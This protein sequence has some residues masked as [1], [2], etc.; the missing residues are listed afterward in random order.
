MPFDVSGAGSKSWLIVLYVGSMS[1]PPARVLARLF[2]VFHNVSYYAK[3]LS[4]FQERG[5]DEFW[6]GYMAFRAAPMGPVEAPVVTATFYN[7][8]PTLVDAAVPAVW[9]IVSPAEAIEL[10]ATAISTALTNAVDWKR[11]D[12]DAV[13]IADLVFDAMGDVPDAGRALFGAYRALPL[14]DLP[15][16]RLWHASTL[17]REY[18]GDGHNIALS[19]QG[20]DG[21]ECHV[22]LAGK[23]VGNRDVIEKIRGWDAPSWD[24]AHERL[25]KRGL[26]DAAGALTDNGA[27][28]RRHIE[29][30]TDRLAA[31]P[32]LALGPAGVDNVVAGMEPIVDALLASGLVPG[33]WPPPKPDDSI[34]RR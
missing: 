8:A 14:P 23:G 33:K 24:A 3:E 6:H 4:V 31:A 29:D 18:R 22:L 34:G 9:D 21:I 26:V 30:E 19:N 12:A 25:A 32:Q 20:I 2:G 11:F 13:A 15:H 7:F 17:W 16:D 10:R 5:V 1:K 27:A 28:L